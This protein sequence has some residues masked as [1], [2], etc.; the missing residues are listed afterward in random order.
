MDGQYALLPIS[1]VMD[2]VKKLTEL[3]RQR[4]PDQIGKIEKHRYVSHQ[5]EVIAGIRI[6][7]SAII[8]FLEAGYSIDRILKEYPS[9]TKADVIA[10][11]RHGSG[12]AA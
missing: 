3:L 1:S 9:L 10:A 8:H 5:S 12:I 6:R 2:D 7:V 4:T 11:K